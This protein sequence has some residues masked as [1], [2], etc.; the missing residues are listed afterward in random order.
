MAPMIDVGDNIPIAGVEAGAEVDDNVP[1][2]EIEADVD[3]DDIPITEIEAGV[4]VGDNMPIAGI[5]VDVCFGVGVGDD[6]AI[7]MLGVAGLKLPFTSWAGTSFHVAPPPN[8][9]ISTLIACGS[10]ELAATAPRGTR[11]IWSSFTC[12]L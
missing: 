6:V 12:S 10:W 8:L 7:V 5:E 9:G 4:E 3:V 1:V 2:A 11:R